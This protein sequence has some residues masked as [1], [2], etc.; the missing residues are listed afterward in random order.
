MKNAKRTNKS[1]LRT[2]AEKMYVEEC[3]TAKAIADNLGVSQQ[4]V[5]R[6]KQGIGKHKD[7]DT[8]REE[9]KRSPF[10]LRKLIN[11]ELARL[12]NGEEAQLDMKAIN[13]AVKVLNAMSNRVSAEVVYSVFREFDTWVSGQDPQLAIVFTDMHKQFLIHKVSEEEGK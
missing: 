9:F 3:L 10:N 1:Q 4:T 5:G 2:L 8:L 13:D 12:T 7:W 11:D 6:W